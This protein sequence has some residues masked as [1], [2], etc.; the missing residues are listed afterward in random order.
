M[1]KLWYWSKR[2]L[3]FSGSWLIV[4]IITTAITC[5]IGQKYFKTNTD[6]SEQEIFNLIWN[7]AVISFLLVY[8]IAPHSQFKS[9]W[10]KLFINTVLFILVFLLFLF[11]LTSQA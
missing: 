8:I 7:D 5:S 2:I 9:R 11:C 4:S 10:Y 3:I 6:L 1:Q